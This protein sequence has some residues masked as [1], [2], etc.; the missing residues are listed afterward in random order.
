MGWFY[1]LKYSIF[2]RP[3]LVGSAEQVAVSMYLTKCV[4]HSSACARKVRLN[5][6][7]P[8]KFLPS[9]MPHRKGHSPTSTVP[10]RIPTRSSFYQAACPHHAMNGMVDV[11]SILAGSYVCETTPLHL[12]FSWIWRHLE[13]EDITVSKVMLIMVPSLQKRNLR[14]NYSSFKWLIQ[15]AGCFIS[16]NLGGIGT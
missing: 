12:G 7:S 14:S 10:P 4:S 16:Y 8:R 6:E 2:I 15:N 1:F 5:V 13:Y 11:I 3:F 9:A